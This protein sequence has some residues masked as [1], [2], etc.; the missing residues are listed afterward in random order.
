[1]AFRVAVIGGTGAF[2]ERV[3]RLLARHDDVVP[4]VLA[5]N[6]ERA[7]ALAG[8]LCRL[9]R[10]RDIQAAELNLGTPGYVEVL[11]SLQPDAVIHTAG[12]FQKSDY[13]VAE[14]CI[15]LKVHYIDL[16]DARAFVSGV[17]RLDAAAKTA[18]VL[19]TSGASSVP[20]LSAAVVDDIAKGLSRIDAID[21]AISPG[22]RAPRGTATVAAILSYVGRSVR[23]WR[24]GKWTHAVG[25][26]DLDT[27][28]LALPDGTG[29]GRR[30]FGVCE[31]PDLTL[32]PERYAV[33]QR[34]A[35]HAGLELPVLH[36]GL[37]LL[38][39]PVRWGWL[40]SLTPFA[41]MLRWM[42]NLVQGLGSDRGGML[43]DVAGRDQSGRAVIRRWRLLAEAGD[44][45]WIPALASVALVRK[46]ARG[47]I[48][49]RG[50]MPCVALLRLEEIFAEAEGMAVRS[51]SEEVRPLYV[52]CLDAVYD[53]LP[54][55]IAQLH[56]LAGGATWCGRA[57][58]DGP[59]GA[60][61]WLIARSLGLPAPARDVA[62]TVEFEVRDGI[63]AW[64]RTF[65]DREFE[66]RQYMGSG[67]EQ[68]LIVESFGILRFAMQA[69]GSAHG[70]DLQLRGGRLLGMP[71]P[72][73][74]LPRI[75]AS[76]R[77]D[78]LGRFRF[79]VDIGVP[80]IGRLVHYCGWL[81]PADA[82]SRA[83]AG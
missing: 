51:A 20:A 40:R 79:D 34:V 45:P 69:V 72:R 21:I 43:V 49:A 60:I 15:G 55:P 9:H 24:R 81:E 67:R 32:F 8:E 68:G 31:V 78:S 64:R 4:I 59:K 39:W 38:S 17:G 36:F 5:R 56:D 19:V 65:G 2:G 58:V 46:L 83:A 12:P 57:D 54:P 74:L 27:R 48:A 52:Q 22:N 7:E 50:A 14:A 30:W 6:R 10:R 18:G 3:C 73:F 61:A 66:S 37:W 53:R 25:W 41:A 13:R 77:V 47:A 80:G 35:F 28:V 16:A 42:A 26:Q 29:L 62:V 11:A 82:I 44:G 71:L 1:M 63:E 75:S 76:E 33:R 23:L 70:I